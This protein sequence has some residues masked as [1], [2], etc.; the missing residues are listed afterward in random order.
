MLLLLPPTL[1][2]ALPRRQACV[3]RRACFGPPRHS[4]EQ[5]WPLFRLKLRSATV[6]LV[7][8]GVVLLLLLV[9]V[10]LPLGKVYLNAPLAPLRPHGRDAGA[11]RRR[12]PIR[13]RTWTL[14]LRFCPLQP[15]MLQRQCC[16]PMQRFLGLL[17][18][19]RVF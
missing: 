11:A 3:R 5:P 7:L 4:L 17:L 15:L 10:L 18:G 19:R 9:V 12:S 1:L 6:L 8:K 14:P 2:P 13:F 16:Q